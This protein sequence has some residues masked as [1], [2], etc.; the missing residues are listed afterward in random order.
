MEGEAMFPQEIPGSSW[1]K[2]LTD[3]IVRLGDRVRQLRWTRGERCESLDRAERLVLD[4]EP[5][6][7]ALLLEQL[8]GETERLQGPDGPSRRARWQLAWGYC[9]GS[10]GALEE[11]W[12]A[13]QAALNET[14]DIPDVSLAPVLRLRAQVE[15]A[16][17]ALA[18]GENRDRAAQ[19]AR[20]A[21]ELVPGVLD[22]HAFGRLAWLLHALA[23]AEHS[24][25]Q[26]ESAR[27]HFEEAVRIG[28]RV[29][30]PPAE[31][32]DPGA[33]V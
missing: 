33:A 28:T 27:A 23:R 3:S 11:A 14:L 21:L 17:V 5:G 22:A 18:A 30:A 20:R 9:R 15:L 16:S 13:F 26:W 29:P 1:F 32:R 6:Q 25:G 4:G 12:N 8:R 24:A 7:A 2:G 31:S 10:A 19:H